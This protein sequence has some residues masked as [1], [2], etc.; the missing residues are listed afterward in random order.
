MSNAMTRRSIG[1]QLLGGL[2]LAATIGLVVAIVLESFN[3]ELS[4]ARGIGLKAATTIIVGL[5]ELLGVGIILWLTADFWTRAISALAF[6]A[7]IKSAVGLVAGT[8]ASP[9]FVVT[10]R[11]VAAETCAYLFLVG[12]LLMKFATS[13]P[14]ALQKTALTLFAFSICANVLWG[15]SQ[16]AVVLGL[17]TALVARAG[18]LWPSGKASSR[19]GVRALRTRGPK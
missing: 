12:V 7:A 10:A 1:E 16:I 13:R 3:A 14:N 19:L 8:A 17:C 9:P 18:R 4:I 2:R 11:P 6:L 5:G 15:M